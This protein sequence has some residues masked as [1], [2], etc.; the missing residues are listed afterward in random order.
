MDYPPP[1]FH[2]RVSFGLASNTLDASFQ[3]VSGIGA[4]IETEEVVEGGE[5]T[6]VHR[7]PTKVTHGNLVLKRG[8]V[9]MDSEFVTWC[10]DTFASGLGGIVTKAVHVRLLDSEQAPLCGWTFAGAYPV[11]WQL[12]S[13]DAMEN[14]VALET[15]EL[16]YTTVTR[17]L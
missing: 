12:G 2:F 5:N 9:S 3:E 11:D 15:V 6:F 8:L 16:A 17:V 1:A 13:L 14:K 10:Q 7:L 4:K